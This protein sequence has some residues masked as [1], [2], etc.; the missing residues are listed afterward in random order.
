MI[1]LVPFFYFV[2]QAPVFDQIEEIR[3]Q[4]VDQAFNTLEGNITERA[5]GAV[6]I[7]QYGSVIRSPVDVIEL[8]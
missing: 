5:T 8:I 4:F 2:A 6:F 7:N 3:G 1:H